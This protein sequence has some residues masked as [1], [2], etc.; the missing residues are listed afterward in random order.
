MPGAFIPEHLPAL[1]EFHVC[2]LIAVIHEDRMSTGYSE[3]ESP[4][5][6]HR[7]VNGQTGFRIAENICSKL[8]DSITTSMSN[9]PLR[10]DEFS[11]SGTKVTDLRRE[12]LVIFLGLSVLDLS[13]CQLT[14]LPAR[15]PILLFTLVRESP[16]LSR[17]IWDIPVRLKS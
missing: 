17:V 7:T 9:V 11:N 16:R 13:R 12:V 8:V 4:S 14:L 3:W 5:R 6:F 2:D 15:S 10:S 1:R